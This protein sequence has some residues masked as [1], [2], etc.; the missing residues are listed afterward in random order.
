[1]LLKKDDPCAATSLV[2]DEPK[3]LSSSADKKVDDLH[4]GAGHSFGN[5]TVH[6]V[7]DV[8]RPS[9]VGQPQI[10]VNRPGDLY[11]QEANAMAERIVQQSGSATKPTM[12]TPAPHSTLQRKDVP[13]GLA[14]TPSAAV[15]QT[16]LSAGQPMDT[17]TRS[18]MEQR[19][20]QDFGQV[21][22]HNDAV[23]HQSTAD[24]Q[25]RAYTHGNHVAFAPGQYQPG[26]DR[27]K[28]LLAHELTH[29]V[30]QSSQPATALIQRE[31]DDTETPVP[32]IAP[33]FGNLPADE[34]ATGIRLRLEQENGKWY[35]ILPGKER[36]RRRAAGWYDFVIQDE[37]VWAEKA[38]GPYGHTEA[39]RGERV[40]FAG[41]VRFSSHSGQIKEWNDGSG[42]YRPASGFARNAERAGFPMALFKPH[43]D[44]SGGV[45][46]PVFQPGKDE[47][48]DPP[49][50]T[51]K[52]PDGTTRVPSGATVS[53]E[54]SAKNDERG[55]VTK[56]DGTIQKVPSGT[57]ISGEITPRSGPSMGTRVTAGGVL[58]AQLVSTILGMLGDK[59]QEEELK[60]RLAVIQKSIEE[61]QAARPELGAYITVYWKIYRGNEGEEVRMLEDISLKMGTTEKEAR[62][63]KEPSLLDLSADP[64]HSTTNSFWILPVKPLSLAELPT[65]YPKIAIATFAKKQG[66]VQG[67]E[68][69]GVAGFDTL[70]RKTKTF[71]VPEGDAIRFAILSPPPQIRFKNG[72][73]HH[74]TEIGISRATTNNGYSIPIVSDVKAA[75]IVPLT[76]ETAGLL[77]Q[78]KSQTKDNLNQLEN[79]FDLIRWVAA[80][81]IRVLDILNSGE[82]YMSEE[83]LKAQEDDRI[84]QY[85]ST[86]SPN[87]RRLLAGMSE[88]GDKRIAFT[89]DWLVQFES[90]LPPDLTE[91]EVRQLTAIM[92]PIRNE[93]PDVVLENLQKSIAALP[94][95]APKVAATPVSPG[96]EADSGDATSIVSENIHGKTDKRPG[97]APLNYRIIGIKRGQYKGDRVTISITATFKKDPT[98][99]IEITATQIPARIYDRKYFVSYPN[100]EVNNADKASVVAV[101]V[102]LLEH[103]FFRQ[104][105]KLLH[106][107]FAQPLSKP[108]LIALT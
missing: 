23:A 40:T 94:S 24:I 48:A 82:V 22:I 97:K 78:Q 14:L 89:I 38:K 77:A 37:V 106:T 8:N 64:D 34:P 5:V 107:L 95:R 79:Q 72:D 9:V 45:Q 26:T 12:F 70:G 36:N 98:N 71:T 47:V 100:Q 53:G 20:G 65:T 83:A 74:T 41:Q 80:D 29:V 76:S 92:Q 86:L 28:K 75:L 16:L 73:I 99:S 7:P 43:P 62:E 15:T 69:N 63:S 105:D 93:T 91:A 52:T 17:S 10:T 32:E 104:G 44:R 60:K 49:R 42:H 108:V 81:D 59:A 66:R 102:E 18:F 1:M 50:G 84:R 87:V 90:I 11:E 57:T 39:A 61:R 85:I 3:V 67:V 30:Q 4:R 2:N 35:E 58:L 55:S 21:R 88:G 46:L 6:S 101:Y 19:F 13:N 56:E 68:W 103:V 31:P 25:A 33:T 96:Q 27:G 54:I 51:V